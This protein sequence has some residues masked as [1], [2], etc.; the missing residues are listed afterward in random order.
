VEE[1]ATRCT[2]EK[3]SETF[4]TIT[5]WEKKTKHFITF[6]SKKDEKDVFFEVCNAQLQ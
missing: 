1:E 2:M 5:I 3:G 4:K 6:H